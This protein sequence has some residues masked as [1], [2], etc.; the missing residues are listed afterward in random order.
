M[1]FINV[2]GLQFIF[3][4]MNFNSCYDNFYTYFTVL[5]H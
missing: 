4:V 3:K 1:I 5:F 2:I